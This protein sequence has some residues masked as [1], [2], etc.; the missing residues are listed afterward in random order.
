MA[1]I[2][3]KERAAFKWK[4]KLAKATDPRCGIS[5]NKHTHIA[6]VLLKYLSFPSTKQE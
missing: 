5:K 3:N 4:K 2:F 1:I 6:N